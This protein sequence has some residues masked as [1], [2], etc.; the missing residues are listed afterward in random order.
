MY[1]WKVW[2]FVQMVQNYVY[3]C[4]CVMYVY[5]QNGC[6]VWNYEKI[7]KRNCKAY[8]CS[9]MQEREKKKLNFHI[10]SQPFWNQNVIFLEIIC[11][12]YLNIQC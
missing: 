10:R 11:T 5:I 9:V 2:N 12:F 6:L 4:V 3:V 7:F 1:G 8:Y